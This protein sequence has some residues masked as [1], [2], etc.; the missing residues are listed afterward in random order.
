MAGRFNQ[1]PGLHLLGTAARSLV[2]S[3]WRPWS[4]HQ[5]LHLHMCW[6]IKSLHTPTSADGHPYPNGGPELQNYLPGPCIPAA[7]HHD[8]PVV[9]QVYLG[10]GGWEGGLPEQAGTGKMDPLVP[11]ELIT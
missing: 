3:T 4:A 1:E 8:S 10:L 11:V 2:I 5:L 9:R 7:S 6:Q